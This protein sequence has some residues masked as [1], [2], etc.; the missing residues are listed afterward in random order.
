M[1][2]NDGCVDVY[3]EPGHGTTFKIYL[4]RFDGKPDLGVSI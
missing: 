3:S 2:Q 4:P 1:K